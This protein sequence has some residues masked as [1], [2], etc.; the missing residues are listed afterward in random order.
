MKILYNR[1]ILATLF[2]YLEEVEIN[3]INGTIGVSP[4]NAPLSTS[5]E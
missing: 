2:D 4:R 3:A 5:T 1:I